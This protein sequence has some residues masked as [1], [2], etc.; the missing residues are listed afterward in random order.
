M[1]LLAQKTYSLCALIAIETKRYRSR[2]IEND[3]GYGAEA[4]RRVWDAEVEIS[5][6]STPTIHK[7]R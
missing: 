5:K 2:K 3:S 7:D 4:A 6:F 1:A